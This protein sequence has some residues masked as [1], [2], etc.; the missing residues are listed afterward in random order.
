MKGLLRDTLTVLLPQRRRLWK[1]REQ[2]FELHKRLLGE[3]QSLAELP[4]TSC[5]LS[6]LR[7]WD[8][9]AFNEFLADPNRDKEWSTVKEKLQLTI[10]PGMPGGVNRGDQRLIFHLVQ[11]LQPRKVLEI[12]THIGASTLHISS[13]LQLMNTEKQGTLTTVD[14]KDVNDPDFK[15]WLRDDSRHSPK[16]MLEIA[17][18]DQLVTFHVSDSVEFLKT[19]TE[20]FDFIFLDGDHSSTAVYREIPLALERLSEG[21][22]IL[23]HDFFPSLEPLWPEEQVKDS[24]IHQSV[25]SGP[26]LACQR[27]EREKAGL[28][29]LPFGALPWATKLGT[30]VTS[31]ALVDRNG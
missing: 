6:N 31:L 19:S 21:G 30:N 5:N 20:S 23:L 25:I 1:D 22:I 11:Y 18:A 29:V 17:G 4:E 12:G 16:E 27:F 14:I 2:A 3:Y 28:C 7:R 8:A 10:F 24:I 26:F 13:A 15:P 9:S